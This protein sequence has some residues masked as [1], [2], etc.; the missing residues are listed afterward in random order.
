MS[1][2]YSEIHQHCGVK[3]TL[4][5]TPDESPRTRGEVILEGSHTYPNRNLYYSRSFSKNNR[6]KHSH[7]ICLTVFFRSHVNRI[8]EEI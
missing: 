6:A 7:L 2:L 1:S 8:C 3:Y 5:I 4:S